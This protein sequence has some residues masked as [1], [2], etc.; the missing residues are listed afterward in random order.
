MFGFKKKEKSTKKSKCCKGVEAG[1][2]MTKSSCKTS[3]KACSG[4]S[5]ST[6]KACK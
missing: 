1:S 4:C 2:D 5:K 6:E 3:E